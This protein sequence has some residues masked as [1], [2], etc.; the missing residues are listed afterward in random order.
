MTNS[1]DKNH[2]KH[3]NWQRR[4]FDQLAQLDSNRDPEGPTVFEVREG[5]DDAEELTQRIAESVWERR[6][7]PSNSKNDLTVVK[8]LP[9][10]RPARRRRFRPKQRSEHVME[11]ST[12]GKPEAIRQSERYW[13]TYRKYVDGVE[14]EARKDPEAALST[15]GERIVNEVYD[16]R[17]EM[18]LRFGIVFEN[19]EV[20]GPLREFHEVDVGA[21]ISSPEEVVAQGN[22]FW[23]L[24]TYNDARVRANAV[25]E[26]RWWT[27]G[28]K[29]TS[30]LACEEIVHVLRSH[31]LL[32]GALTARPPFQGKVMQGLE[33]ARAYFASQLAGWIAANQHDSIIQSILGDEGSPHSPEFLEKLLT[34]TLDE[35]ERLKELIRADPEKVR[36]KYLKLRDEITERI[37]GE[38]RKEGRMGEDIESKMKTQAA[39]EVLEEEIEQWIEHESTQQD[40]DLLKTWIE[41]AKLEELSKSEARALELDLE[42]NFHTKTVAKKMEIEPA[43][44]RKLRQRYIEKIIE[45]KIATGF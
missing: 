22:L 20:Y 42:F 24:L 16:A 8:V 11:V 33:P 17:Q 35:F 27:D 4:I 41:K 9:P 12:W 39:S 40:I 6:A 37:R 26:E 10:E 14:R 1:Y 44:A 29:E 19:M 5:Q 38:R 28:P 43:T 13:R 30:R 36:G 2:D 18:A 45:A 31:P 15:V 23:R 3:M 21:D 7:D 25:L 32:Y 34:L